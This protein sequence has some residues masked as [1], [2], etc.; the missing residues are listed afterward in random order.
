MNYLTLLTNVLFRVP[1]HFLSTLEYC[2]IKTQDLLLKSN[3]ALKIELSPWRSIV[4]HLQQD[5]C[6]YDFRSFIVSL[7]D[8]MKQVLQMRSAVFNVTDTVLCEL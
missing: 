7:K 5:E 3:L 6:V 2:C 4:L 8:F 1:K